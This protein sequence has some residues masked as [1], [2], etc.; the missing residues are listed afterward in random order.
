[1][2]CFCLFVFLWMWLHRFEWRARELEEVIYRWCM[3]VCVH[4]YESV[5]GILLG[6]VSKNPYLPRKEYLWIWSISY[7]WY[8]LLGPCAFSQRW[9]SIFSANH[10][11]TSW[12]EKN[13]TPECAL[14]NYT[15]GKFISA[16]LSY[17]VLHLHPDLFK[18][19]QKKDQQLEDKT[20]RSIH[21]KEQEQN[22]ARNYYLYVY[23]CITLRRQ[24]R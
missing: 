16:I 7:L 24:V 22:G 10:Q 14:T 15:A 8:S 19:L 23:P 1:V 20:I 21:S 3:C 13:L 2:I 18:N 6:Q 17:K 4:S 12:R 5:S 9:G 11:A